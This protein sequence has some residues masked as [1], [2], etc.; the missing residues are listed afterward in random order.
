[1]KK[2]YKAVAYCRNDVDGGCWTP[3]AGGFTLEKCEAEF[4]ER[5]ASPPV[6]KFWERCLVRV[7]V[8]PD[9]VFTKTLQERS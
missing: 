9:H 2:H 5:N 8:W 7:Y 6:V 4:A 3:V 1:M